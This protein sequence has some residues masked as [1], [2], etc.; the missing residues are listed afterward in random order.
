MVK[1]KM[2]EI[3]CKDCG[4]KLTIK[5]IKY[6]QTVGVRIKHIKLKLKRK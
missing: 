1:K 6:A 5:E 4:Q 3:Y 2:E